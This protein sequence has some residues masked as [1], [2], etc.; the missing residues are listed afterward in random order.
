MPSS[1]L[2]NSS[3]LPTAVFR[4]LTDPLAVEISK[5]IS[6]NGVQNLA[7]R[8]LLLTPMIRYLAGFT[9]FL[10]YNHCVVRP[11]DTEVDWLALQALQDELSPLESCLWVALARYPRGI[12][13]GGHMQVAPFY[14]KRYQ[15]ALNANPMARTMARFAINFKVCLQDYRDDRDVLEAL[16]WCATV[17][18]THDT[19]T[20]MGA[21]HN[22][23]FPLQ[24]ML[25]ICDDLR[26][27]N[28][29]QSALSQY[30][31]D[32]DLILR[33]KQTWLKSMESTSQLQD[34]K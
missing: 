32:D 30:F 5:A 16:T 29:F 17:I 13:S 9:A 11:T 31:H 4:D 26:E 2:W 6:P 25:A 15:E 1:E 33:W 28:V 24:E 12:V 21:I 19:D 10:P 27:W 34:R 8:S 23:Q 3:P 14:F 7:R 18:A 22:A 20:N